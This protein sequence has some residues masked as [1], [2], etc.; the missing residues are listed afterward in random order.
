MPGRNSLSPPPSPC[1]LDR[2]R[3]CILGEWTGDAG[4]AALDHRPAQKF[5]QGGE[6]RLAAELADE[7]GD[8]ESLYMLGRGPRWPLPAKPR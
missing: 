6:A 5:R 3:A 7:L 2:R 4:P 8:A 1:Q